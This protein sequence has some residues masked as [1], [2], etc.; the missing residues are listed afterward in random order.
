[1]R[2]VTVILALVLLIVL[3]IAAH[4][5]RLTHRCWDNHYSDTYVTV[6]SYKVVFKVR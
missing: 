2:R 4:C 5:L 6:C 1:V 3:V